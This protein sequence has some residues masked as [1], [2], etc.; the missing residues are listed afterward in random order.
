MSISSFSILKLYSFYF[1]SPIYLHMI[2]SPFT[3][4][5]SPL[6]CHSSHFTLYTSP[7]IINETYRK[8]FNPYVWHSGFRLL[9]YSFVVLFMS[10]TLLFVCF[11]TNWIPSVLPRCFILLYTS[12]FTFYSWLYRWIRDA[13]TTNVVYIYLILIYFT[14]FS[15]HY[16][17]V[18][19]WYTTDTV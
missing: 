4:H 15:L 12:L 13:T 10:F 9:F 18:L 14:F 19:T 16:F 7:F 17:L 3:R 1:T 8:S 11:L 5:Y 6:V 2:N